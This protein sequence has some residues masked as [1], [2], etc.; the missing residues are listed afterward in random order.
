MM[1]RYAF[2]QY[3]VN[4]PWSWG[5]GGVRLQ[6]QAT[7]RWPTVSAPSFYAVGTAI[8]MQ[9]Q[10]SHYQSVKRAHSHKLWARALQ[11]SA[12]L[13]PSPA[14]FLGEKGKYD[15]VPVIPMFTIWKTSTNSPAL[16]NVPPSPQWAPLPV[17]LCRLSLCLTHFGELPAVTYQCRAPRREWFPR[18][19]QGPGSKNLSLEIAC[20]IFRP[21]GSQGVPPPLHT[22]LAPS[23]SGI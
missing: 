1:R 19:S 3:H 10:T 21:S 6:L 8:W 23:R 22:L 5:W 7:T 2:H 14:R 15:F 4:L 11:F 18:R 9:S 17:N 12:R 16:I 13:S 20:T